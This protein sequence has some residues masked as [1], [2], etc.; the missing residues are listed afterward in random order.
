MCARSPMWWPMAI[1]LTPVRESCTVR[2][3]S[4]KPFGPV[5]VLLVAW[6]T[7]G[8][9][10][11]PCDMET[12]RLEQNDAPGGAVKSSLFNKRF[13]FG[14]IGKPIGMRP[15]CGKRAPVRADGPSKPPNAPIPIPMPMPMPPNKSVGNIEL[16]M[17][18]IWRIERICCLWVG[19][20]KG[21]KYKNYIM[22]DNFIISTNL[23]LVVGFCNKKGKKFNQFDGLLFETF[24]FHQRMKEKEISSHK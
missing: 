10:S 6:Y 9:P 7:C 3:V 17:E 4:R 20:R 14:I 24:S 18:F 5:F 1:F 22:L 2:W 11:G 21:E 13:M 16:I 12:T 15:R 8:R 23:L 19:K